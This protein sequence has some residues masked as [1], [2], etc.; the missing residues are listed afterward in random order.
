VLKEKKH[1]IELLKS[2]KIS[3]Q[4][5]SIKY[6]KLLQIICL[7][8]GMEHKAMAQLLSFEEITGSALANDIITNEDIVWLKRA[9]RSY[10]NS[11]SKHHELVKKLISKNV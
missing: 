11:Y 5:F 1:L 3:D 2:K 6:I 10:E 4:S 9:M 8:E 7:Q